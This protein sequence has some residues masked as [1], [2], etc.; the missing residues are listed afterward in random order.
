MPKTEFLQIR[1]TPDDRERLRRAASA[2]HL[3]VSTWA[4]RVILLAV[5]KWEQR[6]SR[7]SRLLKDRS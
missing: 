4:R 3:D 6:Q 7:G 5:D 1:L 2:D